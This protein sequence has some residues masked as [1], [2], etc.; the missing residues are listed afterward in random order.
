MGIVGG[1]GEKGP[2]GQTSQKAWQSRW[3]NGA[4]TQQEWKTSGTNRHK[5][6]N[7][8]G[9]RYLRSGWGVDAEARFGVGMATHSDISLSRQSPHIAQE[10]AHR[11]EIARRIESVA[12][13]EILQLANE[14]YGL[15]APCESARSQ[16]RLRTCCRS[17]DGQV[18]EFVLRY[19]AALSGDRRH[20]VGH[21]GKYALLQATNAPGIPKSVKRSAMDI[22]PGE[23]VGGSLQAIRAPGCNTAFGNVVFQSW[24]A[25]KSGR[26]VYEWGDD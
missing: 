2:T 10:G 26:N 7:P 22:S 12:T 14:R 8:M 17:P 19:L 16:N 20:Q 4:S 21:P 9:I 13:V 6:P 24:N 1:E 15:N 23:T 25:G 3:A 18:R 5:S 11:Y